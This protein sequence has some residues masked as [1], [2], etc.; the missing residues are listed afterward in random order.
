MV[1]PKKRWGQNFLN[2]PNITKKII[3]LLGDITNEE[4]L[5]IGPGNGALTKQ[6]YAK[7][8]TAIEIDNELCNNLEKIETSNLL[9]INEN[10]LKTNLNDISFN[11]V[12]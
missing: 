4:I 8:I 6:I 10:F 11:K 2:D 12:V 5:E 1:R 3:N 9:I 7:K